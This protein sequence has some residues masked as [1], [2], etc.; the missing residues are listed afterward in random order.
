M[1]FNFLEQQEVLKTKRLVPAA[2]GTASHPAPSGPGP[3]SGICGGT[4]SRRAVRGTAPPAAGGTGCCSSR[5]AESVSS[6]LG[7]WPAPEDENTHL[8]DLQLDF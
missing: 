8:L 6:P 3:T 5:T 4:R 2:E 1:K 7:P